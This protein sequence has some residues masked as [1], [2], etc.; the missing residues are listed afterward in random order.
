MK[1]LSEHDKDTDLKID[2]LMT[3]LDALG[4][5]QVEIS[6]TTGGP[7]PEFMKEIERKLA[8]HQE[9]LDGHDG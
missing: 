5:P 3:R 9:R 4:A 8:E 7:S 1:D 2:N 6:P